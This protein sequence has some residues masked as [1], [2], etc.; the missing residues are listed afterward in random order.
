MPLGIFLAVVGMIDV[1][2]NIADDSIFER[3][4][5]VILYVSY[6]LLFEGVF[7]KSPA[8]FITRTTVVSVDGRKPNFGSIVLRTLCRLVPFDQISILIEKND[9]C[10]H[11]TWSKT[12][13]VRVPSIQ[14][15]IVDGDSG[16]DIENSDND[17]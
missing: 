15:N 3:A 12:E 13:V 14:S 17:S 10:W 9:C 6:Y 7:G 16:E 5:G 4:Y 2:E 1:Y 11:G 8:K